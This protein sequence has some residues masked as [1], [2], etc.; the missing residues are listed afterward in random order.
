MNTNLNFNFTKNTTIKIYIPFKTLRNKI[1]KKLQT[2]IINTILYNF[3]NDDDN[4]SS[5]S[6]DI[7]DYTHKITPNIIEYCKEKLL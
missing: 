1:I 5:F 3:L 7:I 2:K 6:D 4:Y